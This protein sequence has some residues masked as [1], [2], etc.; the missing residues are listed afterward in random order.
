MEREAGKLDVQV[1]RGL[2][3]VVGLER[4]ADV[5]D[6][7]DDVPAAGD[8]DHEHARGAE[9]NELDAIEDRHLVRR[10]ERETHVPRC[11]GHEVRRLREHRIHE[12]RGAVAAEPGFDR[13]RR[14]HRPLGFEQQ[15]HVKAIAA[16]GREFGRLTY[17]AAGRSLLLRAERGCSG[18]WP[19]T[20]RPRRR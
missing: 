9:R 5:D 14:P 4:F 17:A 8:D 15:V 20:P 10:S 19:K 7:L 18:R 13:A 16:V 12:R 2:A 1:R 3:K 11:L 6:L